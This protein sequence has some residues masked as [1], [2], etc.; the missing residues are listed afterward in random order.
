MYTVKKKSVTFQKL[1][2]IFKINHACSLHKSVRDILSPQYHEEGRGSGRQKW[3]HIFIAPVSFID[4]ITTFPCSFS[5]TVWHFKQSGWLLSPARNV[6]EEEEEEKEGEIGNW[7]EKVQLKAL[8]I[9]LSEFWV[10]MTFYLVTWS[11]PAEMT[12]FHILNY[13]IHTDAA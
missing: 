9:P 12:Q 8:L 10:K 7:N 1:V 5:D 6:E 13:S 4:T 2:T 3:F 11:L